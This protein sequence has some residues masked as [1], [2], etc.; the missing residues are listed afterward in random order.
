[1]IKV[2]NGFFYV[3]KGI[4]QMIKML[5]IIILVLELILEG[6]SEEKAISNISKKFGIAE[7][8]IR[9]FF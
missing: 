9:K 1:M 4:M 5:Q 6:M 7:E 2:L 8:L 3:R